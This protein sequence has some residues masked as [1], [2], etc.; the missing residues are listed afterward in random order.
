MEAFDVQRINVKPGDLLAVKWRGRLTA[1]IAHR[2]REIFEKALESS[3]IE[4]VG[5]IIVDEN[6]DL[7]VISKDEA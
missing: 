2:L 7:A 4:G 3:N 6:V 1:D 5:V